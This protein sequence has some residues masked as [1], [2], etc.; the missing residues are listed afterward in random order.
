MRV[1]TSG[2]DIW[3]RRLLATSDVV[4]DDVDEFVK[5]DLDHDA[6]GEVDGDTL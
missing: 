3:R 2:G 4:D 5:H 6:D 1:T